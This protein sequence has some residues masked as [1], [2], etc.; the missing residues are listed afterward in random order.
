[1]ELVA[2]AGTT[3]CQ[4]GFRFADATGDRQYIHVG[5]G[6]AHKTSFGGTIA[7]GFLILALL[8]LQRDAAQPD[9]IDGMR[10]EVSTASTS[11]AS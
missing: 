5:L 10:L 8:P 11:S 7:H 2:V 6:Q 9:M 4:R 3:S 1:M